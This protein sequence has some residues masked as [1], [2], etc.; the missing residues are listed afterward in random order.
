ML[1]TVSGQCS[2][3]TRCNY[4]I[5]QNGRLFDMGREWYGRWPAGKSVYTGE[6]TNVAL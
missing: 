1:V 6:Y 3:E 5:D 4:P 2:G